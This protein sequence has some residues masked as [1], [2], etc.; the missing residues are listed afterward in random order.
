MSRPDAVTRRAE[1]EAAHPDASIWQDPAHMG[2]HETGGWH[3]TLPVGEDAPETGP[4]GDLHDLLDVLDALAARAELLEE[5]AAQ[6]ARGD[7]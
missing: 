1:F 4:H 3:G 7:G 6:A 5:R 2:P